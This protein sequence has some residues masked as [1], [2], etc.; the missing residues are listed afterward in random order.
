MAS[1]SRTGSAASFLEFSSCRANCRASSPA[2][3]VLEALSKCSLAVDSCDST[4]SS[5]TPAS[6]S[7]S[8]S[9]LTKRSHSAEPIRPSTAYLLNSAVSALVVVERRCSIPATWCT[10]S[11]SEAFVFRERPW[12]KLPS[13]GTTSQFGS[14]CSS[15]LA[16]RSG[17]STS[18]TERR[19]LAFARTRTDRSSERRRNP[20]APR[21]LVAAMQAR[22]HRQC[23]GETD[24]GM[25]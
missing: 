25:A 2:G 5:T 17:S 20:V 6:P 3:P 9:S 19:A 14:S 22:A 10:L 4:S 12:R 13:G 24:G 15:F 18:A 1:A 23:P 8:C 21:S 11:S 16:N 7:L